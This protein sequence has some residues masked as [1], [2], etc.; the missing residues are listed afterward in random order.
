MASVGNAVPVDNATVLG[1]GMASGQS[2]SAKDLKWEAP[3]QLMQHEGAG[4]AK[5]GISGQLFG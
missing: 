1:M 3:G 4:P 2:W 5:D